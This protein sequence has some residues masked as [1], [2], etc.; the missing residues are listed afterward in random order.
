MYTIPS[1]K[2][3]VKGREAICLA[4]RLLPRT[5]RQKLWLFRRQGTKNFSFHQTAEVG[6]S[7]NEGGSG[8]MVG[9]NPGFFRNVL[10]FGASI[11]L[12]ACE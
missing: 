5:L 3:Q 4:A 8:G 10:A 9:D 6:L 2:E 12:W 1:F 11:I 7:D